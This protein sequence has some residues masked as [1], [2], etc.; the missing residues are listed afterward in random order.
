LIPLSIQPLGWL[1]YRKMS[2]K[3]NVVQDAGDS[4]AEPEAEPSASEDN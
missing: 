3:Y 2:R 1:L 4:A